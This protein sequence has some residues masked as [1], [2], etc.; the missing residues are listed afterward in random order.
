MTECEL[1]NGC[2]EV[3]IDNHRKEKAKNTRDYIL[4]NHSEN[5]NKIKIKEKEWEE[6]GQESETRRSARS[7]KKELKK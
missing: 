5:K 7:I 1:E 2:E 6:G 3:R 4:C